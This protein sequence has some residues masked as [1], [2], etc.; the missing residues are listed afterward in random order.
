MKAVPVI[1]AVTTLAACQTGAAAPVIQ[2]P[3][4]GSGP[5]QAGSGPREALQACVFRAGINGDYETEIFYDDGKELVSV[6]PG[7]NVNDDQAD[8][9]NACLAEAA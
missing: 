4:P 2:P 7:I 9:A 6:M 1:L 3:A 5:V 8:K